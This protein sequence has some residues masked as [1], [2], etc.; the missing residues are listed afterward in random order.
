MVYFELSKEIDREV[1]KAESLG[2]ELVS[3]FVFDGELHLYFN[4]GDKPVESREINLK[5]YHSG[6]LVLS[7][8]TASIMKN[9]GYNMIV[10]IRD[11][12]DEVILNEL[13]QVNMIISKDYAFSITY[14]D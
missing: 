11:N 10:K 3:G 4:N 12:N 9:C 6:L 14:T 2:M 13:R 8:L 7:C 5:D 1:E